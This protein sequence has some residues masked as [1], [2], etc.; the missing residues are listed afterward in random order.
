[1]RRTQPGLGTNGL[2]W[3]AAGWLA[4]WT[5]LTPAREQPGSPEELVR[6]LGDADF[7]VRESASQALVRLGHKALPALETGMQHP[8]P[9]IRRRCRELYP[10]ALVYDLEEKIKRFLAATDEQS[11]AGLPGWQQFR[12]LVGNDPAAKRFYADVVRQ[13]HTLLDKVERASRSE[14]LRLKQQAQEEY[15]RLCNSLFQRAFANTAGLPE[16]ILPEQFALALLLSS[17]PS[18]NEALIPQ[19]RQIYQLCNHTSVRRFLQE[20]SEQASILRRLMV[21]VAERSTDPVCLQPVLYLALSVEFPEIVSLA[22]RQADNK[23]LNASV[24]GL[25]LTVVARYAGKQEFEFLERFLADT[26][27]VCVNRFARG[28]SQIT[29][30]TEMRDLALAL[31]VDV[32]GQ[33]LQDYSFPALQ[34]FAVNSEPRPGQAY[35]PHWYG[36]SSEEEREAALKKWR[37]WRSDHPQP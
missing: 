10:Q 8:D 12:A 4:I 22:R 27:Q 5:G 16:V 13:G 29:I 19:G 14:D 34:L 25:A 28:N 9:E 20:K 23:E 31:L 6:R 1:M 30:R 15:V 7:R 3:L 32:T 11:E 33:R 36:F 35:N 24:R 17:F 18:N 2:V 26:T 37:Q 21:G